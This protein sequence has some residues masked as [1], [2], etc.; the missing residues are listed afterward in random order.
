M[1]ITEEYRKLNEQLHRERSDYG[2]SGH[3]YAQHIME[4]EKISG[5][6]TLLDYGCGKG[7]LTEALKAKGS[8]LQVTGYDPAIPD[9]ADRPLGKF[10]MVV[11]TDV[12]E[13]I[14]P[15]CVDDVLFDI[16]DYSSNAVMLAISTVP[17]SKTLPD[18]RNTHIN[19]RSPNWWIKKLTDYFTFQQCQLLPSKDGQSAVGL[20]FIG[21]SK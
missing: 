1:L 10:E 7:T 4:V 11:C 20:H 14:E 19:I 15:E 3:K 21:F 18:G 17:A 16:K 13:H 5:I 6:K 12:L 2:I 9:F 8:Q